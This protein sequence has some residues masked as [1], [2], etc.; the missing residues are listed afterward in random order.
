MMDHCYRFVGMEIVSFSDFQVPDRRNRRLLE[1]FV[2]RTG[3]HAS[4]NICAALHKSEG[5]SMEEIINVA[6]DHYPSTL[7]F[8]FSTTVL[9]RGYSTQETSIPKSLTTKNSPGMKLRQICSHQCPSTA[10]SFHNM[11][12]HSPNVPNLQRSLPRPPPPPRLQ[13]R[14]ARNID[15][16]QT[17]YL[18]PINITDKHTPSRLP[19]PL[20]LLPFSRRVRLRHG[21]HIPNLMCGMCGYCHWRAGWE[22]EEVLLAV[23]RAEVCHVGGGLTWMVVLDK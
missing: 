12:F 22:G 20:R 6:K 7:F 2:N 16:T 10:H 13:K 4:N 14:P 23:A 21:S 1:L 8:L 5:C 11:K 15:P 17:V 3:S 19:S 9:Y 18:E